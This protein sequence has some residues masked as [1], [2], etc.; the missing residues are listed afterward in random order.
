MTAAKSTTNHIRLARGDIT[1]AA[2]DAIVNAANSAMLGGGGVDGAIHRAAG[3]GLLEACERVPAVNGIRC[4]AG[5]ARITEAG[6]LNARFVI[7]A[8][9]P[10]YGI[11]P[12][13]ERLLAGAYRSS[14]DLALENGCSSV[15]LP[16]ISCGVYGYPLDDAAGIA[17]GTCSGE[18]Y[19]SL[20]LTF[21]LFGDD[22]MSAWSRALSRAD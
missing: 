14:L 9:G 21:Y 12:G 7:H 8:V 10:R 19:R 4:P 16:A 11:G 18:S 2:V 6:N 20:A 13:P 15:A 17:V 1:Q 3:P 5:E 22:V